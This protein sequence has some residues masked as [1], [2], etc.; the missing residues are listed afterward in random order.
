MEVGPGVTRTTTHGTTFGFKH[1]KP[2]PKVESIMVNL[3]YKPGDDARIGIPIK[4]VGSASLNAR[5][6]AN[7]IAPDQNTTIYDSHV[8]GKDVQLQILAGDTSTAYFDW[9]IPTTA[10][11]GTYKI[12]YSVREWHNWDAVYTLDWGPSFN[13]RPAA[14]VNP[15]VVVS[16]DKG[17]Y[18]LA[19]TVMLKG[20]IVN[21]IPPNYLTITVLNPEGGIF[22]VGQM[23]PQT[24]GTFSYSFALSGANISEGRWTAKIGYENVVKSV[25]FTVTSGLVPTGLPMQISDVQWQDVSGKILSSVTID[26]QTMI[27]FTVSNAESQQRAVAILQIEDHDGSTQFL[28]WQSS[29]MPAG[30]PT[31]IGFGWTPTSTGPY[32]AKIFVWKGMDKPVPLADPVTTAIRAG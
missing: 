6:V 29:I 22:K 24:D 3:T 18:A 20:K 17:S 21:Y 10:I 28:S 13:V 5:L 27:G 30:Q 31:T 15:Q 8:V 16:V 7:V 23:K 32:M 14:L 4:N 1:D 25:E 19:D 12:L 9:S 2:E 26:T 11:A